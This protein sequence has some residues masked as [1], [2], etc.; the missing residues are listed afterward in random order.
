[1]FF[2]RDPYYMPQSFCKTQPYAPDD[3]RGCF[4]LTHDPPVPTGFFFSIT[5]F[6]TLYI[7]IVVE[8]LTC[9]HV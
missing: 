9:C 7:M 5:I 1:M 8:I 6:Q 4:V 2:L 3:P